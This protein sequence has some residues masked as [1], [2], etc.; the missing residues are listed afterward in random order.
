M[1]AWRINTNQY[2][3]AQVPMIGGG[4]SS[5]NFSISFI[6]LIVLSHYCA[7]DFALASF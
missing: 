6:T 5:E 4:V 7:C 2:S 3:R 1:I